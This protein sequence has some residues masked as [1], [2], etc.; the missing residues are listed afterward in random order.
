MKQKDEVF[1]NTLRSVRKIEDVVSTNLL[2]LAATR[3][4]EGV[5]TAEGSWRSNLQPYG[6][7]CP[8]HR[9]LSHW[10]EMIWV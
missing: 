6:D 10:M 3:R 2:I 5:W 9:Q 7:S 1:E 8:I 4:K